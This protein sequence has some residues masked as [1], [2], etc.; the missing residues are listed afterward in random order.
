MLAGTG[1]R[2]T[3]SASASESADFASAVRLGT[4]GAA[5]SDADDASLR[6]TRVAIAAATC[7]GQSPSPQEDAGDVQREADERPVHLQE[8]VGLPPPKLE[9]RRKAVR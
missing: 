4:R 5:E 9:L 1:T 7:R 6:I 3:A 8:R 2:A